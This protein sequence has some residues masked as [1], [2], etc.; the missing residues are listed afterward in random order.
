MHFSI[1][2][3]KLA[4]DSVALTPMASAGT[5]QKILVPK[6]KVFTVFASFFCGP[7]FWFGGGVFW[8]LFGV[9]CLF[10]CFFNGNKYFNFLGVS[11]RVLNWATQK[12]AHF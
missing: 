9:F 5:S 1:V 6:G 2:K 12:S 11:R 7:L 10:G 8:A 3:T 4:T